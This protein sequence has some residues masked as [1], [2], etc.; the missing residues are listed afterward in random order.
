ME[1]HL[2]LRI[3]TWQRH[4]GTSEPLRESNE[5]GENVRVDVA[6]ESN[7]SSLRVTCTLLRLPVMLREAVR[8]RFILN[9]R[10]KQIHIAPR[11]GS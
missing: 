7:E 8:V 10:G 2:R 5:R 6:G 9:P 4:H 11:C 1:N 3:Q